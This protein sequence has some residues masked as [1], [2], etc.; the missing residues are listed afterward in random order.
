M[1]NYLYRHIDNIWQKVTLQKKT[2]LTIRNRNPPEFQRK[3]TK[4]LELMQY[5]MIKYYVLSR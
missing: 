5:L 3:F 2:K 4:S 1:Y